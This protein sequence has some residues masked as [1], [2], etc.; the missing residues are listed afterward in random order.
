MALVSAGFGL[1]VGPF[2]GFPLLY[3]RSSVATDAAGE[4]VSIIGRVKLTAGTTK[5]LSAAGGGSISFTN[6]T[7]TTWANGA[8][9]LRVGIQGTS[10]GLENGTYS[11]YGDLAGGSGSMGPTVMSTVSMTSG[12]VNI[13]DGDLIAV[14]LEMTAR[15]GTDSLRFLRLVGAC[16]FPYSTSDTGTGPAKSPSGTLAVVIKFDDG[17]LGYFGEAY[18]PTVVTDFSFNSGSTPDE[19]AF[20]FK[21]PFT[22][23]TNQLAAWIGETDAAETGEII[24]YSDPL[25]TPVA[26]RTY[27]IDPDFVATTVSATGLLTAPITEYQLNANTNYAVAYR[28]TSVAARTLQRRVIGHADWKAIHW[29]GSNHWGGERTNQTGAFT[30]S[31]TQFHGLGCYLNKIQDDGPTNSAIATAVWAYANRTLTA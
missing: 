12:T 19:Y 8:T 14:V 21:L 1:C 27:T 6:E 24:L 25:G 17:T 4:S 22:A 23:T 3:N 10:A 2:G 20:I 29:L 9:N 15:G 13:A 26:E 30:Q 31:D 16:A 5:T 28:P 18:I 11:V 7:T